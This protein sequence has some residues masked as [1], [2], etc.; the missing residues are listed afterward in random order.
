MSRTVELTPARVRQL[1]RNPAAL[2]TFPVL[3][4]IVKKGATTSKGCCGGAQSLITNNLP[5]VLNHFASM[6]NSKVQALKTLLNCEE[7]KILISVD[8]K[9]KS[10]T[11]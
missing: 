6:D 2:Q 11:L 3:N 4:R 5:I 8:G 7:V 1:A 10:V 9:V